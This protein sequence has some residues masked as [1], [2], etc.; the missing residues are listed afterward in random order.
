[1]AL[2]N[3][4][5]NKAKPAEKAY[6]LSDSGGLYLQITPA[7][8]KCWRMKYRF[9]GKEKVLAIGQYP[10][11]SL[12]DAREARDKAKKLL[13]NGQDPGYVKQ[14][15]KHTAKLEAANTFEVIARE[16]HEKHKIKW[17]AKN[18]A[19]NLSLLEN[20]IFPSIGRL[21]IRKIKSSELLTAVQKIEAR[22]NNETAHRTLQICGAI[23]RYAIST[24]RASADL[25]VVLKGALAPVKVQHHASITE[26]KAIG[27]LLRAIDNYDGAYLTK[28]ALKLA[29]FLFVRPGEL[30]QAEWSE[31]DLTKKEWRIGADKMK[32]RAVHIVPLSSQALEILTEMKQVARNSNYVFPSATSNK[33]PMSDNT[34]NMALRRMG[35]DKS[36]IT[37]HGFRSMASTLLHEQGWP[38]DAIERQLAHA[39][40]NKI[41]AAY[42][43]AE[44]LPKRREMMQHWANYLDGLKV[45]SNVS[46][47]GKVA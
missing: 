41:S 21:S 29:P 11:I 30:R 5:I 38:H 24:D 45:K 20:H 36:Q 2:T 7:G 37:A 43:Y 16:W 44:H 18:A 33:R 35:Y 22:G 42:N 40:R 9:L 19:R 31:I 25:S 13:A 6:R 28:Q 4:A 47:I 15:N 3:I 32:M 14:T 12:L 34:L 17:V 46:P 1:M 27:S 8:A 23:F 39:E 26:P 10:H